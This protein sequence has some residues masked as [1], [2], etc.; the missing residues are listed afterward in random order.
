M[1]RRIAIIT[2]L[3]VMVAS[4]AGHAGQRD[5][6]I[7]ET[8]AQTL[9]D[10]RDRTWWVEDYQLGRWD[11]STQSATLWH[12]LNGKG[13]R[14]RIVAAVYCDR[15]MPQAHIYLQVE[16]DGLLVIVDATHLEIRELPPDA[17]GYLPIAT[18]NNP[19][20]AN[21]AWPGEYVRMEVRKKQEPVVRSQET[22]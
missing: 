16:M 10:F 6:S 17:Y 9:A 7:R 21:R 5:M 1:T 3:C 18:Y 8:V 13:I 19:D 2:A 15:G 20:E 14:S 22:E 11:C 12:I 4:A